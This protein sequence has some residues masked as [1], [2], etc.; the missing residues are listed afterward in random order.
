[1]SKRFATGGD[2]PMGRDADNLKMGQTAAIEDHLAVW[3]PLPCE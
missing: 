2:N 3:L 1:M